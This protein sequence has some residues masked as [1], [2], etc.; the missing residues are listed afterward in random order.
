[1]ARQFAATEIERAEMVRMAG[2]GVSCAEIARKFGFN[3]Q[4]VR[5]T[6]QR[7]SP[8][9]FRKGAVRGAVNGNNGVIQR[10]MPHQISWSTDPTQAHMVSL[11]ALQCLAA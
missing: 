3:D 10:R 4:T 11:P 8:G 9:A 5:N 7:D 1:M 6:V 2:D